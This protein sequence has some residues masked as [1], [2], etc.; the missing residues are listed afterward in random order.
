MW[1]LYDIHI[2]MSPPKGFL[3]PRGSHSFT[4]FLK[5]LLHYFGTVGLQSLKQFTIWAFSLL[6]PDLSQFLNLHIN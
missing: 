4:Y 3:E 6:T 5:L 1:K 2:L